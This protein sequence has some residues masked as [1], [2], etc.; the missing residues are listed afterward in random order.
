MSVSAKTDAAFRL[1]KRDILNGAFAPDEPLRLPA[2]TARYGLSATPLR[3]ALSRLTEQGFVASTANC[4]WRV[5]GVSLAEVED[6]ERA[7]LTLESRLLADSIAQGGPD[8]EAEIEAAHDRLV[9]VPPPPGA[10]TIDDRQRWIAAHEAFHAALIAAS[11][12]LWLRR[13]RD[14]ACEQLERHHQ[15]ILF[16]PAAFGAAPAQDTD[17]RLAE[18]LSLPRHTDLM[19]AVLSRDEARALAA[20]AAHV[21]TTLLAYRSLRQ[22]APERYA[23]EQGDRRA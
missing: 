21:E 4:G 20:L 10:A 5:A 14:R 11:P 19:R 22:A 2:L 12:S 17:A 7:R 6:L 18:A 9:R 1:V 8:W 16:A 13:F 3:E 15:A 23:S